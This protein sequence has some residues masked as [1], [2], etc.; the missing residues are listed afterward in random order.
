MKLQP[1]DAALLAAPLTASQKRAV[2]TPVVGDTCTGSSRLDVAS[3]ALTGLRM[4]PKT[5]TDA[6]VKLSTA[7]GSANLLMDMT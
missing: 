7:E 2:S 5:S 4:D 1:V 3:A 6:A